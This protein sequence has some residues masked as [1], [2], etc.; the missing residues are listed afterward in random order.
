MLQRVEGTYFFIGKKNYI[1]KDCIRYSDFPIVELFSN[2]CTNVERYRQDRIAGWILIWQIESGAAAR[3]NGSREEHR[4]HLA[5][6]LFV[7]SSYR[8]SISGGCE[9]IPPDFGS[10]RLV[11]SSSAPALA[12]SSI[13][14]RDS[15]PIATPTA[16]AAIPPGDLRRFA[17]PCK[18]AEK[19]KRKKDRVHVAISTIASVFQ[20]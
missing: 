20:R 15:I 11:S 10:R 13:R 19:K 14:N 5:E 7:V 4:T 8:G 18:S 2:S 16:G 12:I 17:C 6:R 9:S 3:E 1:Y